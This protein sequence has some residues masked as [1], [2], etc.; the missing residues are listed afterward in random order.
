M[1]DQ[2]EY[3]VSKFV[4]CGL[5]AGGAVCFFIYGGH[6]LFENDTFNAMEGTGLGL[7]LLGGSV[8]PKKYILDC[9]TFPFTFMEAA[10]R[11]TRVTLVAAGF[12]VVLWLAGITGNWLY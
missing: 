11:D 12:G 1:R 4:L 10:G 9:A 2:P 3:T 8:D 5:F 6:A 7:L